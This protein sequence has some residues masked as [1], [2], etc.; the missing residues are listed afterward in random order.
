MALF[1]PP[2]SIT[3]ANEIDKSWAD[4]TVDAIVSC[5]ATAPQQDGNCLEGYCT[6]EP[7]L[8]QERGNGN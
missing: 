1:I 4:A 2:I 6:T 5:V 7:G 3:T 8:L